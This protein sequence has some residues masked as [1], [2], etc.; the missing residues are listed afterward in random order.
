[1]TEQQIQIRMQAILAEIEQ[2]LQ[3]IESEKQRLA[4]LREEKRRLVLMTPD[5]EVTR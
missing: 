1:M 4:D 3:A 2:C 5:H